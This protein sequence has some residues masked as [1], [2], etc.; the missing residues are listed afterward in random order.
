MSQHG[1]ATI[2]A[3]I[4]DRLFP[5]FKD[6]SQRIQKLQRSTRALR[7]RSPDTFTKER[8]TLRLILYAKWGRSDVAG[9][10]VFRDDF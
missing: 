2:L 6:T 4:H 10:I 3:T 1:L 8:P 7:R 9:E 5:T